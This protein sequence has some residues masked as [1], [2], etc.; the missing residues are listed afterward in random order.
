MKPKVISLFTGIAGFDLAFS[1]AGFEIV[2]QVEIDG[3]CNKLLEKR[4]PDTRRYTDV[5]EVGKRNLPSA[6]V[7]VGGFPCQDLSVAGKREGLAGERSGL[8]YE[9]ARVIDELEPKWVVIENVPGL[10]SSEGGRDFAIII[11]WLAERGYGVSWRVLDAQ[12]FGVPQ[13]RRRVFI[14]GSFGDGCAAEVLFERESSPGDTAP[15]REKGEGIAAPVKSSTPSRRNGGSNPIAKEFI[16]TFG[17]NNTSGDID[18]ATA[19]NAAPTRRYDFESETFAVISTFQNTGHGYWQEKE[20]GQAIRTPLG[21]ASYEANVVAFTQNQRDEV[22]DLDDKA[23][24]LPGEP[25]SHQQNYIVCDGRN[26]SE[27]DDLSSTLQSKKQGY[28]LNYQPLIAFN[29]RRTEIGAIEDM[30]PTLN[31]GGGGSQSPAIAWHG[32]QVTSPQNKGGIFEDVSTTLNDDPRAMVGVRRL[33]PT[34]CERLQGFPDGWTFGSD[35]TRY[36][37]LGNA[38]AVPVIRWIARRILDCSQ[39]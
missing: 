11:R 4:Y 36:R 10:L 39:E 15:S 31:P 24:S 8:W 22:R 25:G 28:S 37:Q 2:A 29:A 14:V 26:L 7:I 12:Y 19:V 38:V 20:V 34:E 23:G 3:S 18:T 33:T 21:S 35:S 27:Q 16:T 5:R 1:D 17:G 9:F 30:T 32:A 13:R 6:N